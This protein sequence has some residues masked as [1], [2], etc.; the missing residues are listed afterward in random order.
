[1]S[2]VSL[3]HVITVFSTMKWTGKP[4]DIKYNGSFDC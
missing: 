4:E 2:S 1:M 3:V